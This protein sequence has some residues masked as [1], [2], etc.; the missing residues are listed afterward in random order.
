MKTMIA[1]PCLDTVMTRFCASLTGLE[2]TGE[3]QYSYSE[4]SLVYDSRNTLAKKAIA[5]GFD[6]VLWLDTDMVFAPDTFKRMSKHLDEGLDFVCGLYT[7]RKP[8]FKACIY[9]DVGLTIDKEKNEAT[10]T[11]RTI[12][13]YPKDSL[14]EI[15]AC[16]FGG[17]M[18]S[19]KLLKEVNDK[20]GIPFSPI[21][22]FGEDLSFCIRARE[23]GYKLYCDSSIKFGHI[24]FMTFTDEILGGTLCIK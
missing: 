8:P 10:P 20:C 2:L 14:F 18:M 1:I 6:R 7:T 4:S 3:V 13:E 24:G 19:A 16:G 21:Y 22:G 5:E 12:Y 15:Q 23:L 17:V 11:C 9:D